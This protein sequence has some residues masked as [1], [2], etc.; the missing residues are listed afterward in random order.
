MNQRKVVL[1]SGAGGGIGRAVAR[2]F[3]TQGWR[4]ALCD[5]AGDA[6]SAFA[7]TLPDALAITGD[8]RTQ[9]GCRAAV[10]LALAHAGRLDALVN[11]AG[12]WREGPTEDLSEEDYALVLDVNLKGTVLLSAAA[13]PHLRA[14]RGCIVNIA[15]DAGLHGNAGAAA[16]CASKGGVVLFTQALAL[17]LAPDSVRVNAVC[18][19]DVDTPMLAYQAERYGGGDPDGYRARLLQQYPQGAHARFAQ[20]D[21]IAAFVHFLCT[22][23]AAPITGARLPIDFGQTAGKR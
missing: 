20:P 14:S 10:A 23:A 18:P 13:I 7:A 2:L 17:E 4:V 5:I 6:L 19:C 1:I 21:E 3:T 8:V 9:A 16:Y 11:A 12:V 15:S 22:P